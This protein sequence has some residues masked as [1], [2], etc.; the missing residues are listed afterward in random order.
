MCKGSFP[1]FPLGSEFLTLKLW[2]K[3]KNRREREPELANQ[4]D[5][6]P[7]SRNLCTSLLPA[8]ALRAAEDCPCTPGSPS[9]KSLGWQSGFPPPPSSWVHSHRARGLPPAGDAGLDAG[10]SLG[11]DPDSK[12]G[13]FRAVLGWRLAVTYCLDLTGNVGLGW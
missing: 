7:L 9:P 5:P 6:T 13:S 10:L 1:L 8:A 11:I 4:L 12:P 2:N 3:G